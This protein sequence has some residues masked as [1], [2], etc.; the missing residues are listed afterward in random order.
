MNTYIKFLTNEL[1]GNLIE[2]TRK[3]SLASDLGSKIRDIRRQKK[4]TLIE[5]ARLTGV[6][7]ATLSRMET[8]LMVG[9]VKSHQKIAECLG[10][11]L[12]DLYHGIDT[13]H[14]KIGHLPATA[15]K[16]VFAKNDHLKCELLT[17]EISKKKITPLLLTL[18]SHG[19]T[20]V[21][22][23]ER[24]VEKFLWVL[25]GQIVVS[26]DQKEF[27]LGANDTLYFDA[28]LPHQISNTS[29]RQTR[30]FCAVSPSKI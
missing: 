8:G 30:V 13:R 28:S 2:M 12:G 10:V 21:E 23:S 3:N 5:L 18:S 17:V 22:R 15:Q 16:K 1:E 24:G 26:V 19:K 20:D 25:D 9:T 27:Q 29:T 6:A 4:I 7:Q 11:S 14:S